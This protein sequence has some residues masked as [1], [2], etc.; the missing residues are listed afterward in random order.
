MRGVGRLLNLKDTRLSM[1]FSFSPAT[2]SHKENSTW[3][4]QYATPKIIT[5]EHVLTMGSAKR[6]HGQF[7]KASDVS[8]A[9]SMVMRLCGITRAG[10][11]TTPM[12]WTFAIA[13]TCIAVTVVIGRTCP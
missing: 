7:L 1:L 13:V 8:V 4:V 6:L 10:A 5:R 11:V 3:H 9:G 2:L 12:P